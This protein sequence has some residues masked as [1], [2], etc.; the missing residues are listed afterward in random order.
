MKKQ[1]APRACVRRAL[2]LALL[3]VTVLPACA[4][5]N[6]VVELRG[7]IDSHMATIVSDALVA[8]HREFT[9]NSSTGGLLSAAEGMAGRLTAAGASLTA[10]GTCLSACALLLLGVTNKYATEDHG[11]WIAGQR[12]AVS[13]QFLTGAYMLKHGISATLSSGRGNGTNL[14]RLTL[15]DMAT[16]GIRQR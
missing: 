6:D 2:A 8:G 14:Y 16:A 12:N 9:I 7:H 4:L 5:K 10:N 15:E 11:G 3:L 1:T 13:S